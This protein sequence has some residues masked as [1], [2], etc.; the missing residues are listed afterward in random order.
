MDEA[1]RAKRKAA[2]RLGAAAVRRKYGRNY[3]A[4][5]GRKGGT[6]TYQRHG[7]A[8][9]VELGKRGGKWE[10]RGVV[11]TQEKGA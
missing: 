7:A 5:I 10:R 3:F 6:A 9:M 1:L 11:E 8:H 2:A 4:Y